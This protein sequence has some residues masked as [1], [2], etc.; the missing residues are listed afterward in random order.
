MINMDQPW[1]CGTCIKK[2]L[3]RRRNCSGLIRKAKSRGEMFPPAD[4]VFSAHHPLIAVDYKD[5][6]L[7]SCPMNYY[8][9]FNGGIDPNDLY[10]LKLAGAYRN[11]HLLP[12]S[13][14]ILEQPARLMEAIETISREQDRIEQDRVKIEKARRK[15]DQAFK[16]SQGF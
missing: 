4:A 2:D 11:R 1:N 10:L 12:F 8:Y 5:L 13:G 6:W 14:G 15:A 16:N 7:D 3:Q 9:K